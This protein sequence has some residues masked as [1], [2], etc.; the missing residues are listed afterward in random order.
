VLYLDEDELIA[1]SRSGDQD[2]FQALMERYRLILAKTSFLVA[3]DRDVAQDVMQET[4]VQ[5]WRG[6]PAYQPRG[7]FK[8]WLIKIQV[9]QARRQYRRKL[10][11]TVQLEA[12]SEIWSESENPDGAA[13]RQEERWQ[14][15][16]ALERLTNDHR[17]VLVLRYF[18]E[19]TVPEI[20]GA[21][22]CREGTVKSRLS[23]AH[24]HL[25][26]ILLAGSPR[27]E[28]AQEVRS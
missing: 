3:R 27:L 18:S 20:A 17:E 28:E 23:R 2:S 22:S 6:L 24:G 10:A 1:L 5:V 11:P 8:A 4:L 12:A 13:Q 16:Q 7:S 21:L 26:Q 19:L 15:R 9:N 14:V 25:R